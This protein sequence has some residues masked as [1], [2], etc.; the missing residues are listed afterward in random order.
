MLVGEGALAFAKAQGLTL[1]EANYYIVEKRRR[2]FEKLQGTDRT[3]LDHDVADTTDA[4]QDTVGAI[5]RDMQGNLAAATSTGGMMNKMIGRV[6]DSPIIGAGV[7]AD[8]QTCAISATGHGE[9][10][11]R[12]V[13]AKRIADYL[14]LRGSDLAEAVEQ[15]MHYFSERIA[16][17]GGVIAIDKHGY[18]R[19]SY[20]TKRMVHG[21][22]E[23][24]GESVCRF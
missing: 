9:E 24:G 5:A 14:E 11:M 12:A 8:N 19:S 10:I 20:T 16:G 13:L 3:A 23:N 7:Y 15:G 22:I 4:G 21:W 17:Q 1:E 6:G 18:C 2:Q